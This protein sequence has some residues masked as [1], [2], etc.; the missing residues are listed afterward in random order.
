MVRNEDAL[1]RFVGMAC[2]TV[3]HFKINCSMV[4]YNITTGYLDPDSDV[5]AELYGIWNMF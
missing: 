1:A 3:G 5:T 4:H 2:E